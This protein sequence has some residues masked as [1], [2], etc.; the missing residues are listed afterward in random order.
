MKDCEIFAVYIDHDLNH[1][2]EE[3]HEVM[4]IGCTLEMRP[5]I[6]VRRCQTCTC[7]NIE[8]LGASEASN[9]KKGSVL[10]P[11]HM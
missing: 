1:N 7:P 11:A 9:M 4:H 8:K 5:C 6:P 2:Q 10:G 3:S